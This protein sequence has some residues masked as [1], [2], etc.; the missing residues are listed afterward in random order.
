MAARFFLERHYTRFAFVGEPHHLYWSKEREEGF[1]KTLISAGMTCTVYPVPNVRERKDWATEQLRMQHWLNGLVKPVALF[2]AMD[3]RARQ[4]LDACMSAGISVPQEI[5]VLGVDDDPF[6]CNATFPTLSSIQT[7]G[8][9][10][11]YLLAE[12]LDNLMRGRRQ[13]KWN[14][15]IEPLRVVERRSTDATAITDRQ[16]AQALEYIW[17]EAGEKPLSVPDVVKQFGSSRR[18]AEMHFKSIVGRTIM[19]EIRRVKL[20]R[21]CALLAETNLSIG[22]ITWKC[23]F[24]R[25]SHLACLFRK[26][27]D[28]SMSAYRAATRRST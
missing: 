26:Q 25:E 16:V 28:R 7:N 8:K 27:F 6:I 12:H 1:Q 3:G 23:G 21:V 4:V 17:R 22:E 20:E 2:A 11:G 14:V 13:Q 10:A 19:E 24:Q 18:F 9:K 15:K 5:S